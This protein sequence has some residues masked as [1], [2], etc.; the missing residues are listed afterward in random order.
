[1]LLYTYKGSTSYHYATQSQDS[2]VCKTLSSTLIFS[3]GINTSSSFKKN[4]TKNYSGTVYLIYLLFI[5]LQL[6][7]MKHTLIPRGLIHSH[8]SFSSTGAN[9]ENLFWLRKLYTRLQQQKNEKWKNIKTY[10]SFMWERKK[11]LF[12]KKIV[13]L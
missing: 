8:Y 12:S 11:N 13:Y 9:Q 3:K 1:M 10:S 2:K 7:P 4:N 5:K 6:N